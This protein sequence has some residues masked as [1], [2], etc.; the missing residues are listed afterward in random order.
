MN[1]DEMPYAERKGEGPC[2]DVM[3]FGAHPDDIELGCGGTLIK[4]CDAGHS[5]VLV[6]MVRG[7]LGTRG[8]LETRQ[9]EAAAAARVIGAVA[10]ENLELEDGNIRVDR[11]SK[12]RVVQVVRKYRPRMVLLPYFEDRHPDH[13]H[14]S[15]LAYEGAY[16]AGLT[17]YE[18]GQVSYRPPQVIYYMGWYEFEPSFIVDIS[19]QFER[20]MEAIYAYSTQFKP[21]DNLYKQ[22][23]LTSAEFNWMI[24]HRMAYCGSLIGKKYGEGFLVRGKIEVE[25]PLDMCFAS[26]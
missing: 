24:T 2:V 23:R 7:E 8:T 11:P 17:R 26:F 3:A 20:K 19:A 14:A 6:D 25:T 18:T 13:Y 12:H 21:D 9:A 1:K 15:Q 16:L 22:T 10:R 5:V 4:L